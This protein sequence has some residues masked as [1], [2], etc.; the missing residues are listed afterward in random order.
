MAGHGP[1]GLSP[2]LIVHEAEGFRVVRVV[3]DAGLRPDAVDAG[4]AAG[5]LVPWW[6]R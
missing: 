5:A 6:A 2:V 3:G 1:S 4:G